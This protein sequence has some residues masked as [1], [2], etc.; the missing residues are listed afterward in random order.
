MGNKSKMR[1]LKVRPGGNCRLVIDLAA[2]AMTSLVSLDF[3]PLAIQVCHVKLISTDN[4][5]VGDDIL[6]VLSVVNP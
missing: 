5:I 4:I 3:T 6:L 2:L 1:V